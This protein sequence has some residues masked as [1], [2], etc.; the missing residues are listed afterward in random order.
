MVFLNRDKGRGV[1]WPD[2]AGAA[3][4]EPHYILQTVPDCPLCIWDEAQ[5]AVCHTPWK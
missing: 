1:A 4:L 2:A 5:T 3:Q